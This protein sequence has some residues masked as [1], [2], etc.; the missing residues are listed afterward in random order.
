LRKELLPGFDSLFYEP[1]YQ[2]MRQQ[3]LGH[4]MERAHE[5]GADVVSLLHIAPAHNRAFRAITSPTLR[6]LGDS[7]TGVWAALVREP[8]RF[9]SVS[10]E[11]LFGPILHNGQFPELRVWQEYIT[12]R[13]AWTTEQ[14]TTSTALPADLTERNRPRESHSGLAKSRGGC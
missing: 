5:L 13:Y 1:F 4:E 10:T 9:A 6:H 7:V 12:A 3:C 8:D 2:L 11:A 14:E